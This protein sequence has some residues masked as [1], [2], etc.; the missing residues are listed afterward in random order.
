M[1]ILYFKGKAW[2]AID[3]AQYVTDR[4]LEYGVV[5][6]PYSRKF[7]HVI[8]DQ[9]VNI[10]VNKQKKLIKIGGENCTFIYIFRRLK[11]AENLYFLNNFF[12][13]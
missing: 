2:P 6:K 7:K 4:F 8:F 11:H 10:L 13:M 3:K 9:L 1:Q 5:G 12:R